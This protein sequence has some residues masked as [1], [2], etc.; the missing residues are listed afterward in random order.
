MEWNYILDKQPEE[1]SIIVQIGEPFELYG[2]GYQ[3]HQNIYMLQYK[4][5]GQTFEQYIAICKEDDRMPHYWWVYAKDFDY[6]KDSRKR[7]KKGE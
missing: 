2:N 5:Y 1:N 3:L 4:S 7:L 6:P